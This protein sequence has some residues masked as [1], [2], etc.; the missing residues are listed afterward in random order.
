MLKIMYL[1]FESIT[2]EI[3]ASYFKMEI[4]CILKIFF[5]DLF[6][7]SYVTHIYEICMDVVL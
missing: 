4:E 1:K 6:I 7:Q 2:N 5:S 3:G